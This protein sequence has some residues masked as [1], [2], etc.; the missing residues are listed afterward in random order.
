[1]GGD[2]SNIS[3]VHGQSTKRIAEDKTVNGSAINSTVALASVKSSPSNDAVYA[4]VFGYPRTGS[5][6][7]GELFNQNPDA[8]Y[9]YEPFITKQR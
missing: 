9:M 2:S 3:T 7:T 8:L 1:M 5:T 6:F 4:V